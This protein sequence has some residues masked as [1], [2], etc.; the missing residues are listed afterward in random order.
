MPGLSDTLAR[1]AALRAA[2]GTAPSSGAGRLAPLD[3]FG[4]NPGALAGW[5]YVPTSLTEQPAL[6]VVLHGCTQTAAGYDAGAGWSHWADRHGFALLFPEQQRQNNPN[7]CF[8]WFAP[9]DSRRGGGEALSI[10]SMVAAMVARHGIDPARIFVTGLSAGGAMASVL[11]ATYPDVFAGAGIIAG[12]PFG[13]ATSVPQAFERMR[14]QGGPDAAG[15]TALV[16]DAS[17]HWGPWPIVSVWHG[18][19]DATVAPSNAGAI[20]AQWRTLHGLAETPTRSERVDGYPH[21]VWQD[22]GGRVVLEEYQITGMGHGTP[23]DTAGAEGCGSSG[24]YMLETGISSTAHLCRFWGIADPV[25]QAEAAVDSARTAPATPTPPA[26]AARPMPMPASA[27]PN[28]T[29]AS[30]DIGRVIEAALR[31]GG[32]M[33]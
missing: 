30:R 4:P 11:L 3:D 13:S 5:T 19:G 1:L 24:A 29:P 26:L 12:L 18:T 20:V 14:G 31:A 32:L 7:L 23:L 2:S 16:R 33:R 6:V 10:R 8:N 28:R 22:G 15:L 27:A 25:A 21:R 17:P 9:E